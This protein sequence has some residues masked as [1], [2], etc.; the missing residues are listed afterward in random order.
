MRAAWYDR[1]GPADDVLEV[2]ELP[3]PGA[4]PGEVRVRLAASGVNPSD[5]KRRTGANY[6]LDFPRVIPN[7]DGAGIVDQVGAGVDE[8]WIGRRV[9]LY[10]GQR[11]GRAFGTAAEFIV[12]DAGLVM[13]LPERTSFA[14][15]ACLGIPGMTAHRC[16]FGDG[17]VAGKTVLVTGGAGGV[18]NYAIQLAKWGGATVLTTVSGPEKAAIAEKAG[19]DVVINYRTE[20]VATRVMAETGGRGVDRIVEVDFGGNLDVSLKILANNG[21][22][23]AYASERNENPVV[24]FRL[25]MRHNIRLLTVV[26]NNMPLAARQ[27]AQRDMTRLAAESPAPFHNVAAVL[28][29]DRIAE[30]HRMVES[31]EK[32]G[33]VVVQPGDLAASG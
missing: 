24:P 17:P 5:V 12:L 30:A 33:M 21:A 19:A 8:S 13:E 26:L 27:A 23:A 29:L 7:S 18:G 22:I 14:E 31:A 3:T 2:G 1:L 11:G 28:P 20:D 10:N 16:V 25:L 9:W 32:L 4:G 6:T 15:G